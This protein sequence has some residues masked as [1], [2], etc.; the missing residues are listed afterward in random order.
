MSQ[1]SSYKHVQYAPLCLLLYVLA[2]VFVALG[3][4]LKYE[5][6]FPWLFPLIGMAMFS[7]AGS[8][9][10][11]KVEDHRDRLSISFG[12]IPLFRQ[13][14][15]YEDILSAEIGR[16]TILDGWGIHL[17]LRGGWVWNLW[18][19]DCVVLQLR[20]GVLRIGTDDAKMLA[21]FVSRNIGTQQK[22]RQ[23]I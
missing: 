22:S 19:R 18:G 5:Q 23:P 16:T 2:V 13:S 7:G 17:S 1:T 3:W 15:R 21:A 4:V 12:P 20:T 6:P 9:H 10:Y 11:L 14:V 8:F